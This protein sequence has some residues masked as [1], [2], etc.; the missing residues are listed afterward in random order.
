MG[1]Q[2]DLIFLSKKMFKME[3]VPQLRWLDA[4]K[5]GSIWNT[6]F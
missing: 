1:H 3:R 4:S 5:R 6:L 2:E